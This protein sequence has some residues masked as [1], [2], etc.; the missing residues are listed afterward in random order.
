MRSV[1]HYISEFVGCFQGLSSGEGSTIHLF[2]FNSL[3]YIHKDYSIQPH[4]VMYIGQV[5]GTTWVVPRVC[6]SVFGIYYSLLSQETVL[7]EVT[8]RLR[9]LQSQQFAAICK[10]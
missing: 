9:W 6:T 3:V 4:R 8:L 10:R 7:L 2:C 5:H 1:S